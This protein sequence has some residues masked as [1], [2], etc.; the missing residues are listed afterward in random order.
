M[1][2]LGVSPESGPVRL[3]SLRLPGLLSPD[4][5]SLNTTVPSV[6]VGRSE[7]EEENSE[8]CQAVKMTIDIFKAMTKRNEYRRTSVFVYGTDVSQEIPRKKKCVK[9]RNV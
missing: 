4:E 6:L 7:G 1:S 2:A 8:S 3:V 9:F 5:L